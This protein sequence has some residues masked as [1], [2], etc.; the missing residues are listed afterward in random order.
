VIKVK[1]KKDETMELLPWMVEVDQR[2]AELFPDGATEEDIALAQQL[3]TQ[4]QAFL[5][6]L[7]LENDETQQEDR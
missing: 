7:L 2:F 4:E 1:Q 3:H 5:T 6:E